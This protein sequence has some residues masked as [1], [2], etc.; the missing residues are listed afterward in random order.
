MSTERGLFAAPRT[1]GS[2]KDPSTP[3][4]DHAG[5]PI[6]HIEHRHHE[7]DEAFAITSNNSQVLMGVGKRLRFSSNSLPFLTGLRGDFLANVLGKGGRGARQ[8]ALK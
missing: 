3:P 1:F 7:Q 5:P 4:Q 2:P 8:T 6:R